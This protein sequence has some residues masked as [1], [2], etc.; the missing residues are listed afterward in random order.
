MRL[1]PVRRPLQEVADER[2]PIAGKARAVVTGLPE[3]FEQLD[4]ARRGVEAHAVADP[5]VPVRI[6]RQNHR[7][8]ALGGHRARQTSPGPRQTGGEGNPA[9]LRLVV[10]HAALGERMQRRTGFE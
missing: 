10:R 7:H 4:R 8:P 1:E 5:A 3:R 9:R 2:I 6:I